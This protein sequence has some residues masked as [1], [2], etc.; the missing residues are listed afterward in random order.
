MDTKRKRKKINGEKRTERSL[1]TILV[2]KEWVLGRLNSDD[3]RIVDC[4]FQ[5]GNPGKGKVLFEESH[6]EGAI[7]LHLEEDLSGK[8]EEHGGRHPLPNLDDFVEVLEKSGIANETTVIAYD[9]GDGAFA[10]R[11]WWLLKYVGHEKAFILNGGFKEWEEANYPTQTEVVE[12]PQANYS[13]FIH[14]EI[15]ATM[16]DVKETV[17][18]R[19]HVIIDSREQKRYLGIEEAI[20]KK[21]GHIPTAINH[22][23]M[24]GFQNGRFKSTSQQEKRFE[25]IAKDAP[26]IVYCGS[27]ITATPNY[28]ALKEAGFTNVKLYAG[29]FSDW[30][31]FDDNVIATGEERK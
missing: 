29:S 4:R 20:D 2:E 16:E 26:I 15:L 30:I 8:I 3:T 19:D 17:A 7:Y 25:A 27:G 9:S 5:L 23:W 14:E 11:F 28:V 22:D 24:E 31:S 1:M 12:Y 13:V 6:I 21:A 10:A 18:K